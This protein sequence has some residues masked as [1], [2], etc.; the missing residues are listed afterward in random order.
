MGKRYAALWFPFLL[1]DWYTRRNPQFC[2]TP[3]VF[4]TSV[5]GRMCVSAVNPVAAQLGI[6]PNMVVADAKAAVP[7]LNVLQDKQFRKEKLL[8]GIGLWC[9]R[10]T[11]VVSI[12][13]TDCLV[14]NI[15]GCA[16]LWGG[17]EAYLRDI[18]K[19]LKQKGYEVRGGI[20]STIGAA[21]AVA[22]YGPSGTIVPKSRQLEALSSLP[23]TALRLE[24]YLL[25][26]LKKLGFRTIGSIAQIPS[27]LLKRRF[28]ADMVKR[29]AQAL[30]TA[31]E[32]VTPLKPV[33][34]YTECLPC[35]EPI[36]TAKGIEIAIEKLL[37][38]LCKRLVSEGKGLRMAKLSCYRLDGKIVHAEIGTNRASAH[39]QHLFNLFKQ[40]VPTIAPELGIEVFVLEA[41]K[42]EDMALIQELLWNREGSLNN[43]ALAELLDRFKAKDTSCRISRFLPDEHHW[44]ERSIREAVSLAE[45]QT[46]SWRT[47]RPRPTRLLNPPHLIEVSA[48][49]PDYPPMLFRYKGEVHL[50]KKADGPERIEREWWIE[51]GEHRDYY[52]V[53]D[54]QGRRYW[55][56][57]LGHYQEDCSPNWYLHGFF[58]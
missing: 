6:R 43:K 35:L 20:A 27:P 19:Q 32:F 56:F 45:K 57:R 18:Y 24:P 10:Y 11:P 17:E 15:T 12:D 30:G 52:Y 34:P 9:M 38:T 29:I 55:L 44:P 48:P 22:Q 31:D 21:L 41:M 49:I 54:E 47:D 39:V 26:R 5:Q 37:R 36:K 25:K 42:V 4:A 3:F 23:I 14:L 28:G 2:D 46:V 53:E 1:T 16:H 40:K 33:V 58:A 51:N 50:L 13:T 8:E 7:R